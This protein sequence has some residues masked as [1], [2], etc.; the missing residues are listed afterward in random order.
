MKLPL[1]IF[2]LTQ[3]C[4]NLNE[5]GV[6]EKFEFDSHTEKENSFQQAEQ[7]LTEAR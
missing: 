5:D 6:L 1:P 4:L 3:L 2:I 7:V